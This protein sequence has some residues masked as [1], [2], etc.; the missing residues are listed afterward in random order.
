MGLDTQIDFQ[1]DSIILSGRK[2][3]LKI[4]TRKLQ[5]EHCYREI[6]RSNGWLGTLM[7]ISPK[8][9]TEHGG[10]GTLLNFYDDRWSLSTWKPA[11]K[12]VTSLW[13]I[14]WFRMLVWVSR[15]HWNLAVLLSLLLAP[16]PSS[17]CCWVN[18][19]RYR[20]WSIKPLGDV[21]LS[22]GL[23][24]LR[25]RSLQCCWDLSTN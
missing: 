23:A 10:V 22:P 7:M 14:L 15:D 19:C 3:A 12:I 24:P 13:H 5:I 9:A 11:L 8:T 25:Q 20:S 1:S 18:I 4:V 17:I 21:Q 16:L 2:A 6:I